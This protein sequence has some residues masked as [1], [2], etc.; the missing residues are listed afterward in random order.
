MAKSLGSNRI[1]DQR[2]MTNQPLV[3]IIAPTFNHEKFIGQ[4]IESALGQT[5]PFWELIIVDDA[6]IDQTPHII[7]RYARKDR[8][9]RIISHENN[10]GIYRLADT[11]NQALAE[12]QGELMAILEGDDFWPRDKLAR[13]VLCFEDEE[14][15]LSWGRA[16]VT[17]QD[18]I[19]LGLRPM[20]RSKRFILSNRP[21][22]AILKE[23]LYRNIV[24]PVTAVI[25]K[26]A[27][28]SLG[29]FQRRPYLPY[30]DYPT[31]LMLSLQ[32]EF[33][34]M[35][36]IVGY[37]RRHPKQITASFQEDMAIAASRFAEE[38]LAFV[39]EQI[40]NAYDFTPEKTKKKEKSRVAFAYLS[41]AR[42]R[43]AQR[44]WK[45]ARYFFWQAM[46]KAPLLI[47]SVALLGI[48][49]S[50]CCID[51]R[52]SSR[53]KIMLEQEDSGKNA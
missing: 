14:V 13:Q 10:W 42:V 9:I 41:E 18:G 49:L 22:G 12:A 43:L 20:K 45:E 34:F 30:I 21:R 40:K 38:F 19:V 17:D 5:Y 7:D 11:Y 4:S 35:E 47:K 48:F 33:C 16:A 37:W 44:D 2:E 28:I 53:S 50:F 52:P 27:L 25:R 26:R 24:P 39:P 36:G 31:F 23:L 6:S 51:L 15:V 1:H 29:G 8:R 32:G 3:S 46:G